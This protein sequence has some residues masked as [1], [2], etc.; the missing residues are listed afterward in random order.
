V[1]IAIAIVAVYAFVKVS[2][3]E[4][5][6]KEVERCINHNQ[7]HVYRDMNDQFD[8]IYREMDSR[9]DSLVAIIDSRIDKLENK[10]ITK[11]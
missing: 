2:R 11:K 9:Q 1:V 7:S 5:H 6:L 3:L 8:N 10:L 4:E